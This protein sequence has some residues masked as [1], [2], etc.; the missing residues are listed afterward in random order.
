[1]DGNHFVVNTYNGKTLGLVRDK[2]VKYC[3]VLLGG[4]GMKMFI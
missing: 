4:Q 2:E 1:M 3:N